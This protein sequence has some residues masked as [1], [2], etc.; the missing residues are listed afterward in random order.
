LYDS[1]MTAPI[2][3][4]IHGRRWLM[5][6][7]P[8]WLFLIAFFHRP[9]P[10]VLA[11]DL[12]QAFDASGAIVGLLSATYFYGYAG[13]MIPGGLL[14][15]AF[16]VR[17]IVAL[18]G[19]VMALGTLGMSVATTQHTLFTGR[20]LVGVGATVTF[21]GALKIAATW[22]P[23]SAFGTLSA[24]TATVG[25]L[26]SFVATVP[27]AWLVA[28]VGWRGALGI[29]AS[30]TLAGA[31]ACIWIVRDRPPTSETALAPRL[32]N[33]LGGTLRV[34]ANRHT[35]PPFLSFFFFYAA[36]G[37]L[38]L[39]V[40]PY[41][42]DV[43]RLAP[44]TA[45]L[46]ATATSL[47]LL[48]AGPLTGYLSDRVLGRRKAPYVALTIA[49]LAAWS[50]FV[51]TLGA[52]SPTA[53]YG[54]LFVMGAAG[55]AFVLTWP[56]GREVNPPELAGVAV[57]VVNLGGFLGAAFT[58]GFIGAVLDRHWDGALAGGARVYSLEAYRAAFTV[59]GGFVLASTVAALFVQE[60]RCANLH[61]AALH[62]SQRAGPAGSPAAFRR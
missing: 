60:T 5:W 43:Y 8:S 45:A 49:Y 19:A 44:T 58:Q 31:L 62:V 15:D 12:M 34:L 21:I 46:C 25:I 53:M 57:A 24:I 26:G 38:M 3:D 54:L 9:A 13:L 16:G 47:A 55:S 37:N 52:I 51:S 50:A 6:A 22:F 32:R 14:I 42:R 27:L 36:F 2:P 40:I 1:S 48:I 30:L 56:I 29:V 23:P 17:R 20:F 41:L 10:G 28:R 61:G 35:W 11:K 7:I 4:A 18:G 33:V 59:C 39:W